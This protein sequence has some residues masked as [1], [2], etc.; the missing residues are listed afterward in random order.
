MVVRSKKLSPEAEA[1]LEEDLAL[2]VKARTDR[3]NAEAERKAAGERMIEVLNHAGLDSYKGTRGK[4]TISTKTSVT[5]DD[6]KL[7]KRLGVQLWNKITTRVLDKAKLDAYIKT[8]EIPLATVAACST[9]KESDP[10]VTVTA[11]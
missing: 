9:S 8:K 4:V 2:Y 7:R 5:I 6:D 10:F 1:A 11:K 3:D